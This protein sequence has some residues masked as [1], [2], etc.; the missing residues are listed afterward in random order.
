MSGT[1]ILPPLNISATVV[2]PSNAPTPILNLMANPFEHDPVWLKQRK[3]NILSNLLDNTGNQ[4]HRGPPQRTYGYNPDGSAVA[5][6]INSD[7]RVMGHQL[8]KKDSKGEW[9]IHETYEP[10]NQIAHSS[11]IPHATP[12][13]L[14][15]TMK[16]PILRRTMK[17]V[18]PLQRSQS[19]TSKK[20]PTIKRTLSAPKGG[21][22]VTK[23]LSRHRRS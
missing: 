18:N 2:A 3:S 22:R 1:P 4:V 15:R 11:M 8:Q 21:K 10:K 14:R 23:K 20:A 12:I 19:N 17:R 16:R 5:R 7:L 9:Q 13:L 6:R